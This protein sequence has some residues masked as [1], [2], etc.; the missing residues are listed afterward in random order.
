MTFSLTLVTLF[1][2]FGDFVFILLRYHSSK[3]ESVLFVYRITILG[4]GAKWLSAMQDKN[5]HPSKIL[6][7]T[8]DTIQTNQCLYDETAPAPKGGL[9]FAQYHLG[10]NKGANNKKTM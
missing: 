7:F 10:M 5:I 8:E 9:T 1:H 2:S 4:T 3:I 6:E